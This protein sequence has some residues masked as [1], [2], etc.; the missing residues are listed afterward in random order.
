MTQFPTQVDPRSLRIIVG[1]IL[2]LAILILPPSTLIG[3]LIGLTIGFTVHEWAHAYSALRLGD[4]T[5]FFQ[6]RVTFDP[7]AHIDVIGI[8]LAL[9]AGFGWAKPVPVNTRAF[10]PNERR[11]LMIVA[12][13]GPLS[14]I[15]L[16]TVFAIGLRL[17]LVVVPLGDSE[18]IRFIY[19]VWLTIIFFN[20]T[21]SLFN[22]IPLSPLDGWKIMMG[23]LPS[24]RANRLMFYE[25]RSTQLLLLILIIGLAIPPLNILAII[26]FPLIEVIAETLTGLNLL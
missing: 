3:R 6:G 9:L 7:R 15:I 18:V 1:V 16:A 10:Y 12:F 25:Q 11:D 20:I 21:L 23:L 17:A 5:A 2:F 14:N 24:D 19:S 26:M 22:L 13:A 8:S 4:R